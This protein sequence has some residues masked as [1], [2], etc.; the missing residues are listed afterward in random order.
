MYDIVSNLYKNYK[1]N[2]KT[3][4]TSSIARSIINFT[5]TFNNSKYKE[6][7][8]E[9]LKRS[10]KII[11]D[12][13]KDPNYKPNLALKKALADDGESDKKKRLAMNFFIGA[14]TISFS[15]Y[16]VYSFMKRYR[17]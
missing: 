13:Y 10:I 7:A 9:S 3:E 2:A 16:L 12:R 1:Y 8:N 14:S 5:Q 17:T 11:D 15:L 6:Y 4:H